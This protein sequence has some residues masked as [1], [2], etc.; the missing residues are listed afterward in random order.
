MER[1]IS[2]ELRMRVHCE[3]CGIPMYI[4]SL[5]PALEESIGIVASDM[6]LQI[7][8]YIKKP[9]PVCGEKG[10]LEKD[11]SFLDSRGL[12]VNDFE[13]VVKKKKKPKNRKGGLYGRAI[14]D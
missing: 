14:Q 3:T 1:P 7:K 6:L 11:L 13:W 2:C 9:C 5:F 4:R 12:S 8:E 10:L